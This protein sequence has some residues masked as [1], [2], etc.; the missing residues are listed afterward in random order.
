MFGTTLRCFQKYVLY[1]TT[2]KEDPL[3]DWQKLDF[4]GNETSVRI[5]S[6]IDESFYARLQAA[7]ELG[8]GI[9]S[10]IVS[11]ER[12]GKPIAV[13]LTKIDNDSGNDAETTHVVEPS[14][15]VGF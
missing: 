4:N 8:P 14:K 12:D 6:P 9:I 10:D 5:T 1:Y 13:L 3:S 7:T 11:V 15:A 2:N